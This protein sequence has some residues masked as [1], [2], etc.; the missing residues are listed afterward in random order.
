MTPTIGTKSRPPP[1]RPGDDG[2]FYCG[3]TTRIARLVCSAVCRFLVGIEK[4][5]SDRIEPK[6]AL[7][8]E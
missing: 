2:A 5:A 8:P 4:V 6:A 1:D 3:R 7:V